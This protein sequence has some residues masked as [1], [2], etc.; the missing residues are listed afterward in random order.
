MHAKNIKCGVIWKNS[1][2]KHSFSSNTFYNKIN[3]KVFLKFLLNS[4]EL[5]GC[6]F[7]IFFP[8]LGLSI[9]ICLTSEYVTLDPLPAKYATV[10]MA[11]QPS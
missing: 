11:P 6:S 5:N 9:S 3:T 4:L 7:K 1:L 10:F 2:E 8:Y